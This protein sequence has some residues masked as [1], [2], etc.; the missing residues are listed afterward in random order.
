MPSTD[1]MESEKVN[2]YFAGIGSTPH[3][4]AVPANMG[5]ASVCST[6]RADFDADMQNR[7]IDIMTVL[8]DWCGG[9]GVLSCSFVH[10]EYLHHTKEFYEFQR[11]FIK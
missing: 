1:R 10:V 6:K 2:R 3:P 11:Y 8:A 4:H 9:G 7:M 5:K